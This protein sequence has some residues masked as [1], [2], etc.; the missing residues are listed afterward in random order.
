MHVF[1]HLCIIFIDS[2]G[3]PT[4][5]MSAIAMSIANRHIMNIYMYDAHAKSYELDDWVRRHVHELD[6][7]Y[8]ETH[9]FPN[10][11]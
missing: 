6:P 2:E 11:E 9:G 4:Q 5:E 3:E 7:F 8:L 1:L 10:E